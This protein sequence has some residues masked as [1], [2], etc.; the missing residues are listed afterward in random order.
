LRTL[1]ARLTYANLMA[2]IAVFIALGGSSYAALRITSKDV[3][4]DALTGADIKK[5]TGRDVTNNSL[6]GADVKKLRS[7]DVADGS[8]LG[9]DFAAGQ[10][11]AGPKGDPGPMGDAG[12][13]GEPG[14]TASAFAHSSGSMAL[15][16]TSEKVIDLDAGA[17]TDHS[18]PI[19]VDFPARLHV[20]AQLMLFKPTF[21]HTQSARASCRLETAPVGGA[22]TAIGV[23][24]VNDFPQ[25]PDI[26]PG[27]GVQGHSMFVT[28]PLVATAD[29]APGTYQV[30]ALCNRSESLSGFPVGS[31]TYSAGSLDVV[32]VAR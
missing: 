22:F 15:A 11:P 3:P 16:A 31:V 26:D 21:N 6:T 28:V 19:V 25:M 27:A 13:P 1:R 23:P 12:A 10:L 2:T 8:L 24:S 29:V 5:L 30:Q 14:P 4:K 9:A 17:A 20:T 18:G 7:A 32:A